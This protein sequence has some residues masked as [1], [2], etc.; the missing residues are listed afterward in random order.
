M[1]NADRHNTDLNVIS[2]TDTTDNTQDE[3][4]AQANLNTP[5]RTVPVDAN[6]D[7]FP[8]AIAARIGERNLWIANNNAVQPTN[9]EK[10]HL[11]PEY[12][13]S[14]NTRPSDATTDFHPLQDAYVNDQQN[15]TTAVNTTRQRIRQDGDV[16]VNCAAGVSRSS[17]TIAT[18]IAAEE[19]MQF[20][21]VV[22]EIKQTRT[23]A[24]P[25]AK[26]RLGAQAYLA[27]VEGSSHARQQFG[28][29]VGSTDLTSEERDRLLASDVMPVGVLSD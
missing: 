23:H 7:H 16:I 22:E 4:D 21:D 8:R 2:M 5:I 9:L 11:D 12:V 27:S 19:G 17:T 20:A 6:P 26:L 14:V 18:A 25:H 1:N 13:V 10:L 29:L 24:R 15:F 28:E 3:I